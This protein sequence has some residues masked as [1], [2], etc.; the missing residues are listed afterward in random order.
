LAIAR[1]VVQSWFGTEPENDN[2][3]GDYSDALLVTHAT[4]DPNQRRT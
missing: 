2:V 1:S 3:R 4:G